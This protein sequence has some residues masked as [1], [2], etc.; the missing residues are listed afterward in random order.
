MVK[1]KLKSTSAKRLVVGA[2]A[3]DARETKR[4]SGN[5]H[6]TTIDVLIRGIA[7][8]QFDRYT[9]AAVEKGA[10]PDLEKQL[11]LDEHD[12]LVMPADNLGSFFYSAN[13]PSC[14][15]MFWSD[16]KTRK[17]GLQCFKAQ[18]FPN[19]QQI[20]ILD[21]DGEQVRITGFKKNKNGK[22]ADAEANIYVDESLP[23]VKGAVVPNPNKRRPTLRR[24]WQ[25]RFQLMVFEVAG[26]DITVDRVEDYLRRGGMMIGIGTHRPM[27]GRFAVEEFEEA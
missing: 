19:P 27:F 16:I 1:R 24:P 23:R 25:M 17:I 11:Y 14:V 12:G 7:D 10:V 21:G 2:G 4:S 5:G 15:N 26:S 3:A 20:A 8:I 13:Y 22:L 9:G 6:G 18:V